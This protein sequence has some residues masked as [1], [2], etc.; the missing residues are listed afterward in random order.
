MIGRFRLPNLQ[1][2]F[3]LADWFRLPLSRLAWYADC[4]NV[5]RTT[6]SEQLRHYRYR[7]LAKRFG[8]VRLIESP[9]PRLKTLQRAALE[10]IVG[11]VP[12]HRAAHGFRRG[13]SIKTNALLH[14]GQ[15]VVIRMDLED[16]FPSIT[17]ARVRGVFRGMGYPRDVATL[18]AG[19]CTNAAPSSVWLAATTGDRLA[20]NQAS[21]Y[22][23]PHLP[24][25]APT[26]PAL[27]NLVAYRLD[28]RLAGLAAALDCNYTRYADDLVF[29]GDDHLARRAK[30][31]CT[32]VAATAMD[33]GFQLN[34]RKTRIMRASQRQQVAG[35]V[36]NSHPNVS[37]SEFD[38]L[39]ATLT[40]CARHGPASQN[41]DGHPHWQQH[42]AGRVA[43][44]EMLNPARGA[45]LRALFE[46]ISW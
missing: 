11:K 28:C 36:V 27:A 38:R 40:N 14:V 15:R 24:Q 32:H 19:L 26:S 30:R 44:F 10:E 39:K 46:S 3:D 29:S 2:D 21:Q 4:R 5:E 1:D 20:F 42:L 23:A 22:S 6:H 12:P 37:R 7:L 34:F 33:E 45:K 17:V 18:L 31:F 16:F 13:H 43:H 35:V 41:R 8:Q 9:K 25:G